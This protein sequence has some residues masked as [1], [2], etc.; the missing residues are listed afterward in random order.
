MSF[1]I[2]FRVI[3]TRAYPTFKRVHLIEHT[4]ESINTN[5]RK[6]LNRA[7]HELYKSVNP[8]VEKCHY[9]FV[10][11]TGNLDRPID[12]ILTQDKRVEE[13]FVKETQ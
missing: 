8:K 4:G 1:A 10:K 12:A 7:I 11:L 9:G 6:L 2:S 3:P 13:Y 5:T